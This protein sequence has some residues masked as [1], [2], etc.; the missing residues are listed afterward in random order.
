[1]AAVTEQELQ[2]AEKFARQHFGGDPPL[3]SSVKLAQK[4]LMAKR[5]N[6]ERA[7]TLL[8]SFNEI[9]R[10]FDLDHIDTSNDELL[11]EIRSKKYLFPLEAESSN[12]SRILVFVARE[13]RPSQDNLLKH[14]HA[15]VYLL[16]L[17]TENIDVQRH[18]ISFVLDLSGVSWANFDYS[19]NH[20]MLRILQ[21]G[22]PCRLRRAFVLQPPWWIWG[23]LTVYQALVR[24]K[25]LERVSAL[26]VLPVTLAG[27]Q[28]PQVL[29]GPFDYT[30]D[31]HLA[32]LDSLEEEYSRGIEADAVVK[33]DIIDDAWR[34]TTENDEEDLSP[35][36]QR[37]SAFEEVDHAPQ[38]IEDSDSEDEVPR[39]TM[40]LDEI[41]TIIPVLLNSG[42]L[43]TDY[44]YLD[45]LRLGGDEDLTA[46]KANMDKNRYVDILPFN[47]TRV[48]LQ[49]HEDYINANYIHAGLEKNAYIA[50]QGPLKNTA[51]DFWQMLWEQGS[52]QI[53]MPARERESGREKCFVYWP[54]MNQSVT[55][56]DLNISCWDSTERE[57]YLIRQFHVTHTI[58]NVTREVIHY[59]YIAWPD[60]GVPSS[61]KPVLE[62]L[63]QVN[64]YKLVH[65]E[66]GPIIVHCSAGIGRTGAFI[67]I[68]LSIKQLRNQAETDIYEIVRELRLQRY[69]MV[70]TFDQYVFCYQ[71][72]LAA[73]EQGY[74]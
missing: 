4:I 25:L 74:I 32:T 11:A 47:R 73:V 67:T 45:C 54:E 28:L 30:E 50:A 49:S 61:C 37:L 10:E 15:L 53:V 72:V 22:Y 3:P 51:A 16:N 27:Q 63:R 20:A 12:S 39:T 9:K 42:D 70:Q 17:V 29:G 65:P 59:Q 40:A 23:P 24:P 33:S 13:H 64:E 35:R 5:W 69:G 6:L 18:G 52:S 26:S 38:E 2:V 1:M 66:D 68:D 43:K 41:T 14:V 36:L 44:Y 19:L 60:H 7:E 34:G 31:Y 21:N 62:L 57:G 46:A 8:Q 58:S 71:S 55:H 48:I 56:G